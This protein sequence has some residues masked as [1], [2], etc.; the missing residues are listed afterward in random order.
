[1]AVPLILS[2][3]EW[4]D[5]WPEPAFH[6][7]TKISPSFFFKTDASPPYDSAVKKKKANEVLK[8]YKNGSVIILSTDQLFPQ[9]T[10]LTSF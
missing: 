9:V 3:E 8:D 1:M 5:Q 6:S 2:T 4:V 7:E 10:G